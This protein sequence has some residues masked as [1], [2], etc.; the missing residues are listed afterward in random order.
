MMGYHLFLRRLNKIFWL[1][2]SLYF[3]RAF[4]FRNVIAGSEHRQVLDKSLMSV[5]DVGANRGQFAL[6]VRRFVPCARV[7]CFEPVS[8]TRKILENLFNGD[9]KVI[10]KGAAIGTKSGGAIIHVSASDDSSSLLPISLIQERLY[11]G[12]SEIRTEFVKIGPLSD[13]INSDQIVAPAMLKLDVQGYE[14]EA[15]KGCESLLRFFNYV[16]VE[17]SFVELYVGQA[18]A[19]EVVAWLQQ[20]GFRFNGVY[21][22]DYDKNGRAVQGDFHFCNLKQ[23]INRT[24]G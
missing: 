11:P 3:L 5:I 12:T 16:Y 14:L 22:I 6:V 24:G 1:F 17:C 10:F 19:D 20:R 13:F 9:S 4:L 15:L 2:K 23:T 21:N 18:L 8:S 7:V